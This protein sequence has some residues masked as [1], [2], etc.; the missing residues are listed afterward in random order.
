MR[1][2]TALFFV[3]C[4]TVGCS[5]G[6]QSIHGAGDLVGRWTQANGGLDL[7]A[8]RAQSVESVRRVVASTA[9]RSF[10]IR[11]LNNP[12][13]LAF[14][15]PDGQIYVTSGLVDATS[16]DELCACVAHEVGHLTQNGRADRRDALTGRSLVGDVESRA[17]QSAIQLLTA[18]HIPTKSLRT[19]LQKV[20]ADLPDGSAAQNAISTRISQLP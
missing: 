18:L 19:A 12:R 16:A 4:G 17:D 9:G 5:A 15:F 13:L 20:A 14:S 2:W 7:S 6:Q 10:Q 1:V 8:T 11:V 3:I